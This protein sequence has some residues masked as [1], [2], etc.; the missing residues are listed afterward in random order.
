MKITLANDHIFTMKSGG[1][2]WVNSKKF[3]MCCFVITAN[4]MKMALANYHLI[5][6]EIWG[7]ISNKF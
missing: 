6:H 1:N 7:V 3:Q 5:N 4:Y 2:L